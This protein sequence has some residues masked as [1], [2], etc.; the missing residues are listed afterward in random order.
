MANAGWLGC[1]PVT[2]CSGDYLVY[3]GLA[4]VD[5][6]HPPRTRRVGQFRQVLAYHGACGVA[7]RGTALFDPTLSEWLNARLRTELTRQSARTISNGPRSEGAVAATVFN[8]EVNA[9]VV[10]LCLNHSDPRREGHLDRPTTGLDIGPIARGATVW[11][12]AGLLDLFL[13]RGSAAARFGDLE[14]RRCDARASWARVG[15]G[16]R[17]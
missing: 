7:A 17:S 16:A 9:T 5:H 13:L 10:H 6:I 1:G 3:V 14:L 4:V 15:H 11:R 8:S 2:S 12:P